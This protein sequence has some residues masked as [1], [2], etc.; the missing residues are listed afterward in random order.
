[1]FRVRT[2][3]SDDLDPVVGVLTAAFL[4][5]PVMSFAFAD[6]L[7]RRRLEGMWR[8]IAE[9]GYLPTGDST[10]IEDAAGEIVGAALWAASE[11]RPGE[12]F[13]QRHGPRFAAAI[14]GDTERLGLVSEAMAAHHP[15]EPH[16]YLLA[17]GVARTGE[18]IG[19][20]LASPT[21]AEADADGRAC[22]LEAS[23]SRSRDLYLRW[24][25][26]VRTEFAP[27]GGP[28]IWAMWRDAGAGGVD[29]P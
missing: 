20:A 2:A 3:T 21:L 6:D 29:R 11:R 4:D 12:A 1:M 9:A 10:V 25:F 16:H 19:S 8:V 22:Y 14:E 7:R 23:S 24:G 26:E 27:T 18:G 5:D 17:I 28:P 13:W 15:T